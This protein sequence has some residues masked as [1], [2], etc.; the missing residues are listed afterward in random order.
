MDC[1]CIIKVLGAVS[2][3]TVNNE[4][5]M[6]EEDWGQMLEEQEKQQQQEQ[7]LSNKVKI[8]H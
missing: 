3:A 4:V 8:E 1:T 5:I 6:A 7:Q 2:T